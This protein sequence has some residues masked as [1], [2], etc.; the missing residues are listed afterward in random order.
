MKRCTEIDKT[1]FNTNHKTYLDIIRAIAIL[2]IFWFHYFVA[3]GFG[4]THLV[5]LA[6]EDLGAVGTTMFFIVSG[7]ALH[8]KY[9]GKFN[10][11]K[12]YI[13]RVLS[14]FPLFYITFICAYVYT[15]LY[16]HSW[17]WG[18]SLGRLLYTALGIDAYV[19]FFQIHTYYIIG[20][21]FTAIIICIY[22]LYP[23]LNYMFIHFRWITTAVIAILYFINLYIDW[24]SIPDDVNI[25]SGLF[26]FW[27]GML[28]DQYEYI[29]I[30]K[31]RPV[32]IFLFIIIILVLATIRLPGNGA[33]LWKNLF[34]I[35][36][37][38]VL[39]LVTYNSNRNTICAKIFAQTSKYSY[40][41]YLVHHFIIYNFAELFMFGSGI[42]EYITS[43]SFTLI[44]T[45]II[46]IILT[47][48]TKFLISKIYNKKKVPS[49]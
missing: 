1:N 29:I 49:H 44:L 39:M 45:V 25:I 18:G 8:I 33:L 34:G 7:C 30:N 3:F 40:G 19:A 13:K 15:S 22:I 28:I 17:T 32:K 38:M 42:T 10:I 41:I 12:F 21:W 14:I 43:F 47:K 4:Q 37:F 16:L 24:F 5:L 46:S 31:L 36:V 11:K 9:N 35:S 48:F 26:M 23:I 20:E 6:N 2:L 27:I